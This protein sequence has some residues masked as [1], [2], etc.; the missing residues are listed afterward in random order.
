LIVLDTQV[1]LFDALE[2]KRLSSRAREALEQGTRAGTLACSDITLWEIAMFAAKGRFERKTEDDIERFIR[3]LIQSR[4]IRVLP[5]TP[6]IAALAQSVELPHGD[7]ADRIIAATALCER[8]PLVSA[9]A[10]L[11]KLRAPVVIW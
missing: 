5:I 7:P 8:A 11:R 2:P 1:L 9:D 10:K 4:S 6:E 3:A